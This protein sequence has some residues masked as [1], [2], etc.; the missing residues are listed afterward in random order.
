MVAVLVRHHRAGRTG[1]LDDTRN[2]EYVQVFRVL[3]TSSLDGPEVAGSAI[4]I[5][6]IWTP[7]IP[8]SGRMDL[9]SWCRQVTANPTE[10]DYVWEVTC[11]YSSKLEKGDRRPDQ[12][13]ENPTLRPIEV[14]ISM[15]RV[16]TPFEFDRL[17]FAVVNSA[18]EKFDPPVMTDIKYRV[19]RIS[20]NQPPTFDHNRILNYVD[21]INS[22]KWMGYNRGEVK[23]ADIRESLQ[24]EGSFP[25]WRVTYVFHARQARIP[26][27]CRWGN[28]KDFIGKKV[29]LSWSEFILDRGYRELYESSP[30]VKKLRPIANPDGIGVVSTPALLNGEGVAILQPMAKRT[31]IENAGDWEEGDETEYGGGELPAES[32]NSA[33]P[34]TDDG[35]SGATQKDPVFLVYN[36]FPLRK[37]AGLGLF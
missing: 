17:G 25:F 11:R 27:N 37:F 19:I 33:K 1:N 13:N 30:G 18:G 12:Q 32:G 24:W 8:P 21:S 23:C 29:E 3:V 34:A 5:P 15:E 2:R 10:S 28:K 7:Y 9:G 6:R 20:K 16:A 22:D 36:R 4:G 14:E 35:T 31:E 26:K